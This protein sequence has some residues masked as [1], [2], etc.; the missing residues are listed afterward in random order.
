MAKPPYTIIRGGKL[1]DIGKRSAPPADILIKGDTIAATLLLTGEK[2]VLPMSVVSNLLTNAQNESQR[3]PN[4]VKATAP[5]GVAG[6]EL[7]NAGQQLCNPAVSERQAEHD[8]LAGLVDQKVGVEHAE[9][10]SG[11]REGR[12]T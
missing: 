1:L 4:A 6:A 5:E 10:K 2:L 3:A 7:T 11:E 9:D 8:G 12:K